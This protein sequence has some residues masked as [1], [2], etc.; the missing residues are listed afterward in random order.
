MMA[1]ILEIPG[2]AAVDRDNRPWS[3]RHLETSALG[4]AGVLC[5]S[6][7]AG[8]VSSEA[9]THMTH[10]PFYFGVLQ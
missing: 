5:L 8:S 6:E 3:S 2:Y 7:T 4:G 9:G 1:V 10:L